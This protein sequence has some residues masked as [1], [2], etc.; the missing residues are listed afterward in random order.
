[1]QNLTIMTMFEREADLG[2][3]VQDCILRKVLV[4]ALVFLLFDFAVKVSAICVVH[5]NAELAFLGFVHLL[6]SNDIWMIQNF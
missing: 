1:M 2:E 6:E 3:P 5:N 4:L